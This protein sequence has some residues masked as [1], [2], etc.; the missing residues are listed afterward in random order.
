MSILFKD[1]TTE[2]R[3]CICAIGNGSTWIK[4]GPFCRF[5]SQDSLSP[6]NSNLNIASWQELCLKHSSLMRSQSFDKMDLFL[7]VKDLLVLLSKSNDYGAAAFSAWISSQVINIITTD[8]NLIKKINV[9]RLQF[10]IQLEKFLQTT[11]ESSEYQYRYAELFRTFSTNLSKTCLSFDNRQTLS[12]GIRLFH[13]N[14]N[15]LQLNYNIEEKRVE[16]HATFAKR[17]LPELSNITI[18]NY[19]KAKESTHNYN[20]LPSL[21]KTKKTVWFEDVTLDI[22][23]IPL[24]PSPPP[25]AAAAT[26]IVKF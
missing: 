13:D 11:Q 20:N 24:P 10:Q 19:I 5:L 1:Y 7:H 26:A 8:T 15:N 6:T 18:D 3:V 16:S 21:S 4:F 14:M 25:P 12:A 9:M 22:Q 2:V 23:H 17:M